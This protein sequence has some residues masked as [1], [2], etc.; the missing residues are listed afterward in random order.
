MLSKD[1]GCK[2]SVH[3]PFVDTLYLGSWQLSKHALSLL[4]VDL[5]F[6]TFK[7]AKRRILPTDWVHEPHLNPCETL[8]KIQTP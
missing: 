3:K 8:R 4:R 6:S 1:E 5:K 2:D 7:V